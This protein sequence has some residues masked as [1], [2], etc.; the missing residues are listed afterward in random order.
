MSYQIHHPNVNRAYPHAMSLLK[1]HGIPQQTRGGMVTAL[2]GPMLTTLT[3]PTQRVLFHKARKA[4]PFFHLFEAFWML[5]GWSDATWLDTYVSDFSAR[6]AEPNGQQWGAYGYRWRRRFGLDQLDGA[7]HALTRDPYDRRVVISMWDP[8]H[9]PYT[10]MRDVPCN[11]IMLPRLFVKPDDT[12]Y[13][14]L[15]VF[16]RS[17]DAVWG[18][19]GANVVHF[20]VVHEYLAWRLKAELGALHF[21]SNNVHV[22]DGFM[23]R[24]DLTEPDCDLY[25]QRVVSARRLFDPFG[26]DGV[27]RRELERWLED[28]TD[29]TKVAYSFPVFNDLLIPM[30]RVHCIFKHDSIPAAEAAL[31]TIVHEDWRLAAGQFLAHVRAARERKGKRDGTSEVSGPR[32][33]LENN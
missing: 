20:S 26:S 24:Y 7:V 14:E 3:H 1:N 15:T 19:F 10:G 25:N 31:S 21:M 13:L 27:F 9:D 5:A 28:T 12:Y 30:A 16:N 2:P 6:F 29:P 17:H 11:V 8:N 4:N 22:Y 32:S 18:L 23:D 33:D